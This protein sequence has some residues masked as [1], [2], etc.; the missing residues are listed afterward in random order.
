MKSMG[1]FRLALRNFSCLLPTYPFE[2]TGDW[3]NK[4]LNT[5]NQINFNQNDNH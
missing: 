2:M 5:Y 3:L 1:H 4:E